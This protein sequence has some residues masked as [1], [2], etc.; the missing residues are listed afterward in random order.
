MITKPGEYVPVKDNYVA[1][2]TT[3]ARFTE[4]HSIISKILNDRLLLVDDDKRLLGNVEKMFARHIAKPDK[5]LIR[6]KRGER[7]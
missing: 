6:E 7:S 1:L 4:A 5:N 2:K 3:T